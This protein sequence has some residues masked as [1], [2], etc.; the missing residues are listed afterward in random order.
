MDLGF[1]HWDFGQYLII[2]AWNLVIV[3]LHNKFLIVA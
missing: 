3:R 2:G 1:G